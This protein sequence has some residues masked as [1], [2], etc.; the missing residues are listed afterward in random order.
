MMVGDATMET[1]GVAVEEGLD[2]LL[3]ETMGGKADGVAAGVVGCD[4]A[5][6]CCE[7]LAAARTAAAV[8]AGVPAIAGD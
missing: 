8:G 4:A 6:C 3:L 1:V 7:A 5:A 2:A